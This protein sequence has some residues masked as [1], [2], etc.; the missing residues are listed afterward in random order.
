MVPLL[1]R[2]AVPV[3]K[4]GAVVAA[5]V[6]RDVMIFAVP[7]LRVAVPVPPFM[8]MIS[9]RTPEAS[10]KLTVLVVPEV[11]SVSLVETVIVPATEE[12]TSVEARPKTVFRANLR[13][14]DEPVVLGSKTGRRSSPV[15]D[16]RLCRVG[17][18][19]R[20]GIVLFGKKLN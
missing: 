8:M 16:V 13:T 9:R 18:S 17:R 3:V 20:V 2:R 7:E 11:M 12:A 4:R 15:G 10:G 1:R 5:V 6:A 14:F 19:S